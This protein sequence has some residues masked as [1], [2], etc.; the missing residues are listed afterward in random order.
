MIAGGETL[1]D[2][3][4]YRDDVERRWPELGVGPRR[5]R[6]RSTTT[7]LPALVAGAEALAIA[8]DQGGL[9]PGGDGGAGRRVRRSR[10]RDLPVFRE[11]FD[12]VA[13]FPV[14]ASPESLG[15]AILAAC[16]GRAPSD[17]RRLAASY[18]WERAALAHLDLYGRSPKP[19]EGDR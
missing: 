10:S 12:G 18:T 17:G 16:D 19:A 5:A 9:R 6:R 14:D 11:V 4:S 8:V 13:S 3:R 2:Y 1:F 15:A 7:E